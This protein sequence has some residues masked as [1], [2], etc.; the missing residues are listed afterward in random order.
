MAT[1]YITIRGEIKNGEL[2]VDLPDNVQDGEVEVT[3]PVSD[4]G[5]LPWEERPWAEDELADML[6]FEGKSLGEIETG[7]WEDLEITDSVSFV[8]D[9]RRK[10][11]ERH[12][13]W[14]LS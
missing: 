13:K 14:T 7:G 5:E 11:E 6:N 8:E 2:K 10:E 12:S 1:N 9:L 4:T 3:I